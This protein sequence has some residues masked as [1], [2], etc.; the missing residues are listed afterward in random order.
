MA[1]ETQADAIT[2]INGEEPET[3]AAPIFF[4][5]ENCADPANTTYEL[6]L[7]NGGGVTQAALWSGTQNAGCQQ[8]SSRTDQQ[9]LCRAVAGNLRT[10]EDDSTVTNLTLQE[11]IDTG[12]VD[13]ENTS[14]E[15]QPFELYAFRDQEPG[16]NDVPPE[17]YGVAPFTVDVTPPNQLNLTNSLEQE[18]SSFTISW[19]APTD[20]ESIAQY[21]VYRGDSDDPA[22]ATDTG[23]TAGMTARSVTVSATALGLGVGESTYLFVSA[24][25]IAAMRV[26]DGNEGELSEATFV[27]AAETFGVCSDP[28]VDCSGCSVSPLVLPNGQPSS[29]LWAL[30]LVCAVLVGWR[31]RR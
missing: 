22:A 28:N 10:V 12:I 29:G 15:G 16:S 27:T 6:T 1:Q 24:V 11:L 7:T 13:C 17:G 19:N 9:L 18:G 26:G 30:A 5:A 3:D 31:L 21:K 20:S 23:V 25:D 2:L 4:N 8:N 14:L